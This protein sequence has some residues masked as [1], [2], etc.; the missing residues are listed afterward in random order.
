MTFIDSLR[1]LV[2]RRISPSTRKIL[3]SGATWYERHLLNCVTEF[4]HEYGP[5]RTVVDVG[6][7][8]MPFRS[9]FGPHTNYLGVD[10]AK[11]VGTSPMLANTSKIDFGEE[12]FKTG[13]VPVDD[14]FADAVVCTQVLEHAVWDSSLIAELGRIVKPGGIIICTVPCAFPLHEQPSDWRRYTRFGLVQMGIDAGLLPLRV[15]WWGGFW[16]VLLTYLGTWSVEVLTSHESR[17]YVRVFGVVALPLTILLGSFIGPSRES[18]AC[19]GLGIVWRKAQTRISGVNDAVTVCG[20][21][22]D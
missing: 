7:G 15:V 13:R 4:I 5:F 6:C 9:L 8:D 3:F 16:G 2:R 19:V 14:G 18:S 12:F 1:P 11:R 10:F 22:A 21:I 20:L 17:F